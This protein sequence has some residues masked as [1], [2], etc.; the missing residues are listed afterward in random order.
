MTNYTAPRHIAATVRPATIPASWAPVMA[1][2]DAMRPTATVA[3]IAA[4]YTTPTRP[5]GVTSTGWVRMSHAA[6]DHDN[7]PADRRACRKAHGHA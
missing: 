1:H 7:T 2:L 6:C 3:D 4:A 5:T